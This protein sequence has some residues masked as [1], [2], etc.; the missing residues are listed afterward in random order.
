MVLKL[1]FRKA[2]VTRYNLP[3][4]KI[5]NQFQKQNDFLIYPPLWTSHLVAMHD[6]TGNRSISVIN[7]IIHLTFP[8]KVSNFVLLATFFAIEV[9]KAWWRMTV[10][11][12][13]DLVKKRTRGLY[14]G[15][16]VTNCFVRKSGFYKYKNCADVR[17]YSRITV[18]YM[19]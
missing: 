11:I 6:D 12:G 19:F 4:D 7:D 5:S 1:K 13:R 8:A 17:L 9:C 16:P 2:F 3:N 14:N 18:T 15:R 10:L